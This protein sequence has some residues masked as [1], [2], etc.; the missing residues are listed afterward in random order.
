M[1]RQSTTHPTSTKPN[2][3]TKTV[4]TRRWL[5]TAYFTFAQ[6]GV[7]F[8]SAAATPGWAWAGAGDEVEANGVA[9]FVA[10]ILARRAADAEEAAAEGSAADR[11][12]ESDVLAARIRWVVWLLWPGAFRRLTNCS[13][14][15]CLG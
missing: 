11:A 1:T 10:Q 8:P 4:S 6:M 13:L 7:A 3:P 15:S 5:S 9:A 2:H 14:N 12:V